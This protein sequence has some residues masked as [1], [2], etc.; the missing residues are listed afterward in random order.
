MLQV[1]ATDPGS[2]ECVPDRY[3]TQAICDAAVMEDPCA[4]EFVP[5]HFKS[6]GMFDKALEADPFPLHMPL[7]GL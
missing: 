4:L 1:S 3:K 7:I 5:D 6:Q 2:L